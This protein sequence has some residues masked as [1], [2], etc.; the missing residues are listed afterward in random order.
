M[1]GSAPLGPVADDALSRYA[2]PLPDEFA[3]LEELGDV[4]RT[5]RRSR[6][7]WRDHFPD[8]TLLDLAGRALRLAREARRLLGGSADDGSVI[9]HD[10]I[11]RATQLAQ[12][13][14]PS[15]AIPIRLL[16]RNA[17]Q[18]EA[19]VRYAGSALRTPEP[20]LVDSLAGFLIEVAAD[21]VETVAR[22]GP[23][24]S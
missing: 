12:S 4:L 9:R 11:D 3:I 23:R 22:H 14:D 19:A 6:E 24:R 5:N 16:D 2:T 7:V 8:T 10:L 1:T 15:R 21:T 20:G 17:Q 13:D 18:L